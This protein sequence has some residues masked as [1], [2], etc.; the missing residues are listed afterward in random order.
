[1]QVWGSVQFGGSRNTA[2]VRARAALWCSLVVALVLC[3]CEDSPEADATRDGAIDAG[4]GRGPGGD[5]GA[6][7]AASDAAPNDAAANDAA[8]SDVAA[9]DASASDAGTTDAADAGGRDSGQRVDG[10]TDAGDPERAIEIPAFTSG[11]RLRARVLVGDDGSRH[12][13]G[14]R[15]TKLGIDCELTWIE[16]SYRCAPPPRGH[17]SVTFADD[18]CTIGV[19]GFTPGCG[20]TPAYAMA[21]TPETRSCD[22]VWSMTVDAVGAPVQ[23][24]YYGTPCT[25]YAASNQ[26]SWYALSAQDPAIFAGA[27]LERVPLDEGLELQRFELEDGA[28]E[29]FNLWHAGHRCSPL[30]ITGA[31]THCVW[32]LSPS[33][34]AREWADADCS[35]PIH[36]IG[37]LAPGCAVPEVGAWRRP[38]PDDSCSEIVSLVGLRRTEPTAGFYRRNSAS[39]CVSAPS[40]IGNLVGGVVI[41]PSFAHEPLPEVATVHAGKSRLQVSATRTANGTQVTLPQTSFYDSQLKD[42]CEVMPLADGSQRCVPNSTDVL[43]GTFGDDQCTVPVARIRD[44]QRSLYT[45]EQ[46]DRICYA[47]RVVRRVYRRTASHAGATYVRAG[48]RCVAITY[49]P[50]EPPLP[51]AD[52]EVVDPAELVAVSEQLE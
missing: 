14:W 47:P 38:D 36:G 29:T 45:S 51:F 32:P 35:K 8:A 34:N 33:G 43:A 18:Q 1:M 11:T 17:T 25:P 46:N 4:D 2:N 20:P 31:G 49:E 9:S 23:T 10:S 12:F 40:P 50:G 44:C 28:I 7:A 6:D 21:L 27:T 41:D 42:S 48:S 37:V 13:L 26:I 15:D 3:G 22:G 30:A 5:G 16:D 39:A 24:Q 52:L 19:H